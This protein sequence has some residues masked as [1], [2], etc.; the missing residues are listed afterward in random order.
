MSFTIFDMP[1]GNVLIKGHLIQKKLTAKSKRMVM[2]CFPKTVED[3]QM[4]HEHLTLTDKVTGELVEDSGLEASQKVTY[5]YN[6]RI[7]LFTAIC[8]FLQSLA[9]LFSLLGLLLELLFILV[10]S[11]VCRTR[12]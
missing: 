11:K 5:V 1:S 6:F 12:I 7:C 2:L 4:L 8:L 10:K 9:S 3:V